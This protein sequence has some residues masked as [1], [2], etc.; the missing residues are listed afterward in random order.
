MPKIPSRDVLR[1]EYDAAIQE[2]IDKKLT[3]AQ[4]T[5]GWYSQIGEY[6]F[7][8]CY[9][10][11]EDACQG[12]TTKG[13][14]G[15]PGH[16]PGA[17]LYPVCAPAG[18]GKTSF[19]LA[20]IVAMVRLSERDENAPY[21]C[22]FV[23]E[24]RTKADGIWQQLNALLPG[25]VAIWS[26]DHTPDSK[27][28]TKVLN[29]AATFTKDQ[30]KNYP[31]AVVTHAFFSG[32]GSYKARQVLKG[33]HTKPRALTIID[34]RIDEVTLFD[35]ELSGAQKVRE[36][37][38]QDVEADDIIPHM[39]AL[40]DFMHLRD[41]ADGRTL[42]KPTDSKDWNKAKQDL[43]WFR[44]PQA[45]VYAK[46]YPGDTNVMAVFGFAKSVATDHAFISRHRGTHFI[47]YEN[48]FEIAPGTVLLDATADIDGISQISPYRA[49]HQE[50]PKARYDKLGIVY[51]PAHTKQR[52]S[53]HLRSY[54]N[55]RGYVEWMIAAIKAHVEPGQKALVV[56]RK[57][58]FD[59][60]CV[61]N[62]PESDPRHDDPE[63]FTKDFGWDID[64][65]ELSA[66]HW[67]TGIGDNHWKAADVVLL[68]DEFWLPR[69]AVIATTQGLR[70]HK[71]SEGDLA[72][73]KAITSRASAV[74][75]IAE[76]HLHRMAKQMALRGAAR[77]Y[78]ENG[79]CGR[80]KLVCCGDFK[81]LFTH[82]EVL[83][84][85]AKVTYSA[86][87]GCNNKQT[88]AEALL[89][90]LSRPNLPPKLTQQ[91]ISQQLGCQWRDI[92]K[93]VMKSKSV[94]KAIANLGWTYLANKGCKGSYFVR[95]QGTSTE[96]LLTNQASPPSLAE[97]AT[98][99]NMAA[100]QPMEL[101]PQ[102]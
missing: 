25:K 89:A 2:L 32:K 76:G 26:T 88:R 7:D 9:R 72:T 94:R 85:G 39:D 78:D 53:L 17:L 54:Q 6:V 73:M 10:A 49:L 102:L 1:K 62:W 69:R 68:F 55:R 4:L 93:N 34:E 19:G 99:S 48:N 65:R 11:L 61:P 42:D 98:G 83:F 51:V 24:Q 101:V 52:L 43:Q 60:R 13:F 31:I 37:I 58:L 44:T 29:P 96:D 57:A 8:T 81:L 64:G 75:T 21:G 82:S 84:P 27:K 91:W 50:V 97:Q 16:S 20:F 90:L 12:S 18:G 95:T 56:C 77:S 80:Q 47:G 40:I 70:H 38:Q 87:I 66:I 14:P 41:R 36:M 5:N 23:C 92:S 63:K 71:A 45:E 28:R 79:V 46:K 74:D 100:L 59:N 22:L 15:T 33:G 3:G 67:G 35:V 86:S 30:L